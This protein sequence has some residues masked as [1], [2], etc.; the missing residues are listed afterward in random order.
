M[1]RY[2][3]LAFSLVLA[4]CSQ[5]LP[6]TVAAQA[7]E[8]TELLTNGS[9]EGDLAPLVDHTDRHRRSK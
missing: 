2:L 8:R 9:F 3:L 5:A 4:A 1:S 6:Q 7:D